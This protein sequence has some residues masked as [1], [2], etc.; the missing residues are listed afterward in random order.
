[1]F[2]KA[3]VE[4]NEAFLYR[5]HIL[6]TTIRR[7]WRCPIRFISGIFPGNRNTIA[8]FH[9]TAPLPSRA[10]YIIRLDPRLGQTFDQI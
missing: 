3:L 10:G 1:M 8:K 7:K 9:W 5:L 6:S 4:Q 2:S